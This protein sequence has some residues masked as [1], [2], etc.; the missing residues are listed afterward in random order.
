MPGTALSMRNQELHPVGL[1]SAAGR[2]GDPAY[3]RVTRRRST[4][5]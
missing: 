4:N 1:D 5:A 2:A 3:W